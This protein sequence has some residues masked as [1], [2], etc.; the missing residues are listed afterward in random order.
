M[1][2]ESARRA[3]DLLIG[4][5]SDLNAADR[6]VQALAVAERAVLAAWRLGDAD[7]LVRA[8]ATQ[9]SAQR[10]L[11]ENSAAMVSYIEVVKL[12][13]DPRNADALADPSAVRAIGR[14]SNS[15]RPSTGP[16]S[17]AATYAD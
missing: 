4:E 13:K 14:P 9:A 5:S 10:L 15:I 1:P 6:S 7:L 16:G 17:S 12:A 3:I 8:L 2:R 11:G